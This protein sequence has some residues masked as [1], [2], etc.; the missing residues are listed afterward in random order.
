MLADCKATY[1]R[2]ICKYCNSSGV[3][4]FGHYKKVQRYYCKACNRK[5]KLDDNPFH[6]KIPA[7][8]IGQAVGELIAGFNLKDILEKLYQEYHYRPSKSLVKRWLIKY[9]D[10]AVQ[11]FS[12]FHPRVGD[13]WICDEAGLSLSRKIRFRVYNIIDEKTKFVIASRLLSF[14]TTEEAELLMREAQRYTNKSPKKIITSGHR[15]FKGGI[16]SVFGANTEHVVLK[17]I[18]TGVVTQIAG[19]YHSTYKNAIMKTHA[20]R[21]TENLVRFNKGWLIYYNYFRPHPDLRGKAPAEAAKIQYDI[22]NWADL[23]RSYRDQYT[24]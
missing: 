20:I 16:E 15:S 24:P 1:D 18:N 22:K 8:Y 23:V 6:G 10:I 11:N 19:L 7:A 9:T 17:S 4:K 12:R 2:I 3:V 13:N 21:N 14:A 5:F